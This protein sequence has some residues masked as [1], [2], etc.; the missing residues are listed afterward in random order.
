MNPLILFP[1]QEVY[2]LLIS[3]KCL[4]IVAYYCS[5]VDLN[6]YVIIVMPMGSCACNPHRLKPLVGFPIDFQK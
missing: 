1:Q 6:V 4:Q 5:V 2:F 3:V